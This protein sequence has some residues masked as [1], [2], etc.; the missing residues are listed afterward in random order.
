[1]PVLSDFSLIR[2]DGVP[3]GGGADTAELRPFR[4]S[5][6]TGGHV[7]AGG[8]LLIFSVLMRTAL[9]ASFIAAATGP[10]AAQALGTFTW[11]I[12]PYCNRVSFTVTPDGSAYRLTGFDDQCGSGSVPAAGAVTP[13]GDGSFTLAFYLTTAD[14]RAGHAAA[15]L[16]PGSYSGPWKDDAGL[17]GTARFAPAGPVTG[18][19]RPMAE[20]QRR[21]TGTCPDGEFIQEVRADGSVECGAATGGGGDITAV[22][23]G[24]GLVGGGTTGDVTLGIAP[25]GVGALEVA[26][27]AVGAAEIATG[28]V[29]AAEIDS[30][31]VQR[32][33]TGTCAAG[34]FLRTVNQDGSVSCA[35]PAGGGD[36]TAVNAGA[37]LTGGGGSGD[38]T[39][40]L[41]NGGVGSAQVADGSI[42]AVDVNAAE[43]QR[44]VTGVCAAGLYFAAIDA[45]GSPAC[46]DGA[47]GDSIAL[48]QSALAANAGALNTGVGWAAL[49]SNT[50]GQHNTA[51]GAS[52]LQSNTTGSFN[53]ALGSGALRSNVT[54]SYSVAVGVEALAATTAGGNT[55]IGFWSLHENTLGDGNTALGG[56]TLQHNTTGEF[57]TA[58]GAYAMRTNVIGSNNVGI[59]TQALYFNSTGSRNTAVGVYAL[60]RNE[61]GSDNTAV[62]LQA[63][64]NTTT[65]I[66][67]V[68]V[69]NEALRAATGSYGTAVGF[70]ALRST[71]GGSNAALGWYAGHA[72]TSGDRNTIIGTDALRDATT[73]SG[74]IAIGYSAA[75]SITTGSDNIHIGYQGAANESSTIRIGVAQTRA[76]IRGIRGVTTDAPNAVAVVIDSNGQLGT[77]SSSRRTKEDVQD[78]GGASAGL[79][80][81]RPVTFRYL[82]PYGGG[83]RP[84]DYGLIAEEVDEVYPDLVVRN[85]AGEAET[86]QYHKLV[87]M[88]LNELQRLRREF[89]ELRVRVAG[90]EGTPR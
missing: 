66:D 33:V 19:P 25:G 51:D 86:V 74:N 81:L 50:T 90:L 47:A 49:A 45:A 30:A 48:G 14:G 75:G 2:Q 78:M 34:A 26:D 5:F 41:A 60:W 54:N 64:Y 24:A 72:L 85:E 36:I 58:L 37:G 46:G 21:V 57:N 27:G 6:G 29:G 65:G 70:R 4:A 15:V 62:G 22:T 7:V 73:G 40:G 43:I 83:A 32:R 76:F 10:A 61:I 38:V 69:G 84:R 56:N 1:M 17:T 71:T 59:G 44:R 13:N 89:E 68:A 31:A 80:R 87:P 18:S 63:L 28:A 12:E 52:A 79:F 39:L 35:T 16:A 3:V 67:N 55:A 53:T 8:A 23:A 88:L 9:A 77:V 82:R 20:V 11:Q 42:G